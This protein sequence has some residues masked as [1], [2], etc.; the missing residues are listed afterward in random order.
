MG[1]LAMAA[2]V[3]LSAAPV[4]AAEDS[5]H[6]SRTPS[7]ARSQAGRWVEGTFTSTAGTRRYQVYVPGGYDP[8]R[9]HMLVVMLHGCTQDP[10]DFARGTRIAEH[11]ERGRFLAV[12]PEQPESANPKKCWNWY[13]P[14]H[15]VRSAGEPAMIDGIIMQVM[16]DH[17]VDA[18][19]VHLAGISAGAAMASLMAVAYPE[20]FASIALHSGMA[21]RPATDVMSALTVMARGAADADTLGAAALAAM[22]DRA[23]V[24]PAMVVHGAKDVVLNPANGRQATQQWL[25]TNSR[26]LR[27]APLTVSRKTGETTGYHWTRTCHAPVPGPC[28]VEEWVIEELG[29][30]WSGGS[31]AGTYTD[32]HGPDI[33]AEMLRFFGEHPLRE[34]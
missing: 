5:G 18:A 21:W 17:S 13:E 14:V 23:R 20:R 22:G 8:A 11:A 30:A 1:P 29:H 9:R 26:A 10:A 32:E 27:G 25:V 3:G 33:T 2:I 4:R 6:A 12:L 28:V 19:R 15:Q 7:P 34:R 31:S 16:R 24:V